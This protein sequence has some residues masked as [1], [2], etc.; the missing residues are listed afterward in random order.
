MIRWRRRDSTRQTDAAAAS[1]F[2]LRGL[3]TR[4]QPENGNTGHQ[5]HGCFLDHNAYS[6]DTNA[7]GQALT[8][9]HVAMPPA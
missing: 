5:G 6:T 9:Y 8:S 2:R 1:R 7:T 4:R 3:H